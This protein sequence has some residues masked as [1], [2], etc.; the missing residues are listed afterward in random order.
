MSFV[1]S[2]PRTGLLPSMTATPRLFERLLGVLVVC[3]YARNFAARWGD[4]DMGGRLAVGKLFLENGHMPRVDPFAYTPT[5]PL[6]VDHVWLTGV[7]FYLLQALGGDAAII[8]AKTLLGLGVLGFVWATA[9]LN[10]ARTLPLMAALAVAMPVIG[11]GMM[12]RAQVFTYFL[13]A[14]WLYLLERYR[15]DGQTSPLLLLPVTMLAWAN[16]HGGFLAGLGL[17]ALYAAGNVHDRRRFTAL[18]ATLVVSTLVTL[19]NPYGLNYWR[20]LLDAVTMHRPDVNEWARPPFAV[21]YLQFWTLVATAL[22]AL[23]RG[24]RRRALSLSATLAVAVTLVISVRSARHMP[25]FAICACSFLPGLW[26]GGA[27][28]ASA[29]ISPRRSRSLD[30]AIA[31]C[32]VAAIAFQIVGLFVLDGPAEFRYP[33]QATGVENLVTYPVE[34]VRYAREHKLWGNLA[35]PFNW[36]EYAIWQ[37]YPDCR[38]SMD[39]RYETAYPQRTVEMVE[40]FFSAAPGWRQL[41]DDH[42]TNLVLAP[43]SAPINRELARLSDWKAVFRDDTAI[44]WVRVVQ[45][46]PSRDPAEAI[47]HGIA[48][49]RWS[50]GVD[51]SEQ[52]ARASCSR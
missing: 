13:F 49:Q 31:A 29:G 11:Y 7:V 46:Q 40:Q 16:L 25:L 44:L 32:L 52:T 9:R 15:H 33:D 37:L 43:V 17:L 23:A 4:S 22:Y 50:S 21:A 38:V 28:R 2:S 27:D 45:A 42:A 36:G 35:V 3:F 34:A 30:W 39:G 26:P 12:P 19:L 10:G 18:S 41:L 14:M 6:W 47:R 51:F 8:V 1:I 48:S 24:A 20:Y 5:L